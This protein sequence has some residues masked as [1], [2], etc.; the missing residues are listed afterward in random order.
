MATTSK[1]NKWG[2]RVPLPSGVAQNSN[3][4]VKSLMS[5]DGGTNSIL[6]LF[7]VPDRGITITDC[8]VQCDQIDSNATPT[9]VFDIRLTDGTTTKTLISGSTAGQ[10]GNFVRASK[11]AATEDGIGFT[12]TNKNFW[13]EAKWTTAVATVDTTK[14]FNV[15]LM[16]SGYY[17]ASDVTD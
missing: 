16:T 3:F 5:G 17:H 11:K 15:G 7:T 1:G 2:T 6:K 12:T 14:T 13:V 8:F 9:V 4:I 10:A